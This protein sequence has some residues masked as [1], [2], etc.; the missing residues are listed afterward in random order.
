MRGGFAQHVPR[1]V[2]QRDQHTT[3]GAFP[4]HGA[5]QVPHIADRVILPALYG[6]NDPI[7]IP[8]PGA[9]P[10]PPNAINAAIR[11]LLL[12]ALRHSI[13]QGYGPPLELMLVPRR[14]IPRGRQIPR[15]AQNIKGDIREGILQATL[16]EGNGEMRDINPN[17]SPPQFF[18]SMN[19]SATPTKGIKHNIAGI[20]GGI[21]D[22]FQQREGLLR[23][24]AEAFCV[25][26]LK[27]SDTRPNV[28][29]LWTKLLI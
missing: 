11:T 3:Q 20:G 5:G 1:G 21:D 10:H 12:A 16:H 9:G 19:R 14:Q 22:A 23:G 2:R 6:D 26:C 28:T 7:Q 17:P 24:V 13:Q 27:G 15:R 29:N 8:I 18:G 25:D 4:L